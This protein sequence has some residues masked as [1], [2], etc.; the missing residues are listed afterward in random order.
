MS[1]PGVLGV[2]NDQPPFPVENFLASWERSSVFPACPHTSPGN[3]EFPLL[4]L[5]EKDCGKSEPKVGDGDR[6]TRE[7]MDRVRVSK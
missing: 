2:S 3:R 5:E 4:C 7:E 6:P 1:Y